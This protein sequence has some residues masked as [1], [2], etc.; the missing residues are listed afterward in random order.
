V[1]GAICRGTKRKALKVVRKRNAGSP[2][3]FF[4]DNISTGTTTI[5]DMWRG[6]NDVKNK[7]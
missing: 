4:M 2:K 3:N 5:T 1:V 7:P 6:Y